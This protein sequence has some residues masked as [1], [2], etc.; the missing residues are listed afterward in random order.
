MEDQNARARASRD[1]ILLGQT[2]AATATREPFDSRCLGA[3]LGQ[4]AFMGAGPTSLLPTPPREVDSLREPGSFTM[5]GQEP[6]SA[7]PNSFA[8]V[9][10]VRI[11]S[12]G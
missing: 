11:V 4:L 7:I 9:S 10:E 6:T 12:S 5:D 3:S 2:D 1:L 8:M